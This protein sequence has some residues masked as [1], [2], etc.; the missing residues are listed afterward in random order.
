[1]AQLATGD[2]ANQHIHY[3]TYIKSMHSLPVKRLIAQKR[4]YFPVIGI[5]CL[6]L[7]VRVLYNVT[8][9]RDYIPLYDGALYHYLG[10]SLIQKHCY[11]IYG[12]HATVSRAPLWPFII[13]GIY[14]FTGLHNFYPRLFYCFLGSGT[15]LFIYY[16]ARELFGKRIALITGMLA[17]IYVG[18]FIYDGWLFSESLYT[19]CLIAFT[20]ALYQIQRTVFPAPESA[21]SMTFTRACVYWI[22]VMLRQRWVYLCGIFLALAALTRPNGLSLLGL[23]VV[24]ACIVIRAKILPWQAAALSCC[25]ITIIVVTSVAP[26]TY[27]NYRV[28]HAFIP[29]STGMGEVLTGAYNDK[30]WR[31]A[32]SRRGY[33]DTPDHTTLHDLPSF[34]MADEKAETEQALTWIRTHLYA[35]PYMLSLHFINMWRPDVRE[36]GA[37]PFEEFPQRLSSQIIVNVVI[38]GMSIPVFILA[39]C[40]L[41]TTWIQRKK[42]LLV[43]YLTLALTTTLNVIFYS[44]MRF[45]APMEPFLL[46]FVGGFLWWLTGN[47]AGTLRFTLHKRQQKRANQAPEPDL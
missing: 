17:A 19:F 8:I 22:K 1:M 7:L 37:F 27:R 23:L 4:D 14:F 42:Q 13:A 29:I 47:E 20:Y 36:F 43:I 30:T 46:L 25:M 16:W 34:S 6:A 21:D 11:C 45:R 28:V 32:L 38:P 40:G 15:C 24:W 31:G 18:L 9:A 12:Y 26:W 10:A 44:N 39:L 33:W 2:P 5:F 3:Q 35:M 41:L